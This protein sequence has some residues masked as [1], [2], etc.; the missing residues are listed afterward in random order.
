MC[1]EMPVIPVDRVVDTKRIIVKNGGPT[2]KRD[3][4]GPTPHQKKCLPNVGLSRNMLYYVGA[5]G[6]LGLFGSS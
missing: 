5:G 3:K 6:V 2:R 4:R 1:K